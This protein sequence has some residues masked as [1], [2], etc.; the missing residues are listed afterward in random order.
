MYIPAKLSCKDAQ[1]VKYR[2]TVR[3]TIASYVDE[4][5]FYHCRN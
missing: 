5:L 2:Y 1:I 3:F 4:S